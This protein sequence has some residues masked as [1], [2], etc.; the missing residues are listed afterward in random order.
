MAEYNIGAYMFGA[1]LTVHD[2]DVDRL[3]V[4]YWEREEFVAKDI[5]EHDG[6]LMMEVV[7]VNYKNAD[8]CIADVESMNY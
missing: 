6:L 1:H 5:V 8:E 2:I 4:N 3:S 7:V